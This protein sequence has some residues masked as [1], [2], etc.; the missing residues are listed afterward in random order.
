MDVQFV[1]SIAPI[2]RDRDAPRSFYADALGLGFEGQDGN[3]VFTHKLEGTEHFGLWSLSEAAN[4]CFGTTQW[5]AQIP[6]PRPASSSRS[7]MS[8]LPQLSSPPRVIA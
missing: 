8:P 5:P 4:A 7:L 3:Y 1:T 6:V 2:V